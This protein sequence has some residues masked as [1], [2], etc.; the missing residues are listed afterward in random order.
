[1]VCYADALLSLT[2]VFCAI[3]AWP[4]TKKRAVLANNKEN[5]GRLFL[6]FVKVT[7][8]SCLDILLLA[9]DGGKKKV[10]LLSLLSLPDPCMQHT[11]QMLKRRGNN[12]FLTK[13]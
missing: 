2:P 13:S 11:T 8:K 1:M 4:L 9:S 7:C 3:I 12:F 10:L 6:R 5:K